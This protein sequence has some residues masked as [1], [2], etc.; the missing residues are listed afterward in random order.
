MSL[1]TALN[2]FDLDALAKIAPG[3]ARTQDVTLV[4]QV[5]GE[6]ILL[7]VL[8]PGGDEKQQKPIRENDI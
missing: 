7:N 3:P 2:H 4:W 6:R 5:N 1:K 8:E